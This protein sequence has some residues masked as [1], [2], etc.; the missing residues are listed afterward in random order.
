MHTTPNPK[1]HGQRGSTNPGLACFPSLAEKM[2][3][4]VNAHFYWSLRV[5]KEFPGFEVQTS[6]AIVASRRGESV[7][8]QVAGGIIWDVHV[9]VALWE[10]LFSRFMFSHDP[11]RFT[12]P[13]YWTCSRVFDPP[14]L[15]YLEQGQEMKS[16]DFPLQLSYQVMENK[17]PP[18]PSRTL[19]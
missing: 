19:F 2:L 4:A 1:V 5:K 11:Q 18:V 10:G 3:T 16:M 6:F 7:L 8:P 9:W 12:E 14:A 13:G 17:I 15:T